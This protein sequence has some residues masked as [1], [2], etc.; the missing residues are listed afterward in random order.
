[1]LA[2]SSAAVAAPASHPRM[3][4]D[5]ALR[6]TWQAQAKLPGGPVARAIAICGDA[7]TTHKYD[8]AQ[9]Q[10]SEWARTI[11]A[12]LVAWAATGDALHAATTIKFFTALIDDLDQIGDGKGGDRAAWRDSGF[13]I[14]MLGPYTAI[15]YDWLYDQIAPELRARARQR[16]AS[17]LSWYREH[18]YRARAAGTNYQAGYLIAATTIAIAQAGEGDPAVWTLVADELR[19]KDMARALAAGGILDGGDWAEGWQYGPLS[20]AE[21]ALA[22]RIAS[23]AGIAVAGVEPWLGGLLR[24]HVYA[25]SPTDRVF[26]GGDT[27]DE[28][29]NLG[30]ALLTLDAIALG[31]ARPDD[32]R[33]A[34]G[35]IARLGLH[36]D[37]FLLYDALAVGDAADV[38]RSTW[39]TWYETAGSGTLYART[40]WDARA[41]WLVTTCQHA[42]EVDHRHPDAGNFV[43]SRGKDDV[44]VDPSPYGSQ[45]TLTSNA[46]TIASGRLPPKY[47][48]SQGAWGTATGW[49]WTA[50][51]RSGVVVARCD[52]ADQ[53]RFQDR[54][55]DI[56]DALR[57]LVLLPSSD[58]GDASL[59][60]V[61]RAST[62][63][64]GHP[65]HL[66][67]RVPGAPGGLRLDGDVAAQTIG[68]TRL[69]I[70][71]VARSSGRPAIARTRLKDCFAD[72]IPKG[73]CDAARLSVNDLH[74]DLDGPE[75]SAV[76][77]ISAV[78]AGGASPR[79][80]PLS[81]DGWAGVQIQGP[82]DA[83]VVWPTRKALPLAYR[84]PKAAAM[85]HVILD[86]H[87]HLAITARPD[88][89]GCGVS[90]APD[91]PIA[92]R[93]AIVV[94]D[95]ACRVTV[96]PPVPSA[97][98]ALGPKPPPVK[99]AQA[100]RSGRF[101]CSAT[102]APGAPG[103]LL[104]LMAVF[105]LT[106]RHRRR[107]HARVG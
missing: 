85:T 51:T 78:A 45:S 71:G 19:G 17:W 50:Q 102:G 95:D 99:R 46:P 43:L 69:A 12:C 14:R 72:D 84:A 35:E 8:G 83:I 47:V 66:R 10:G 32:R 70:A 68:A 82:R 53:F 56:P 88:G 7:R 34:R 5:A 104:A 52:Y 91:G 18:G 38:P 31:D 22:A 41:V 16:W 23:R 3:L 80:A 77:V 36:D 1:M 29:A 25:L 65:M 100:K 97:A 54:A 24:R 27:E 21:Y 2:I 74:L 40:R 39:P 101:G 44:I 15:A 96:D 81:G 106:V 89:D 6:T 49:D 59:V 30:P 4:L 28:A 9:Y 26:A 103:G 76:H 92:G 55:S 105:G 58:G 93:P 62:G 90:V 11:Q 86:P 33:W 87:D 61:D 73:Q 94:V 37:G 75:P 98:A 79:S 63:G 57:D 107:A 64:R 67:F 60:V 42:L 48:P 20:V 13:A